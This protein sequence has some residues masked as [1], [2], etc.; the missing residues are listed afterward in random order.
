MKKV[1]SDR[2]ELYG[3][4]PH[5]MPAGKL[6]SALLP[7]RSLSADAQKLGEESR[8]GNWPP[9]TLI[10]GTQL[11]TQLNNDQLKI[12]QKMGISRLTGRRTSAMPI[13]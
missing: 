4:A 2:I 3:L 10:G 6:N 1:R 12:G 9:D 7:R 13:G 8:K 11:N 5:N